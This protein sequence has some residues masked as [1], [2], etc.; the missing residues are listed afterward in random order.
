MPE[1]FSLPLIGGLLAGI[2]ASLCCAGP[3]VLL[4]L[5]VSGAWISNLTALEPYRPLFIAIALIALVIAYLA[6]HQSASD[7]SCEEGKICAEPASQRWYKN[8]FWAVVAVVIL[9]IASPYL[10]AF[11]YG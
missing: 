1:K 2:A 3:L 6:I 9:A 10:I 4:S 8:I 11:M 7:Q 5:G